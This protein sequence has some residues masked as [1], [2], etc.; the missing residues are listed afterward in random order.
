[1]FI[2][3]WTPAAF[4][5]LP[6]FADE[7][8]V[9]ESELLNELVPQL[10]TVAPRVTIGSRG[11][12]WADARGLSAELLP[13]DLLDVFHRND[14]EKVRA[15]ISLVPI[16]A[17]VAAL[18]GKGGLIR[19]PVGTEREFLAP[20]PIGVLE[21]SPFLASLLDGIGVERCADLAKLDLESIE[22]RFGAEGANLWRLARADDSRRIF[23][24]VPRSTGSTTLCAT[25]S[26]SSSSSTRSSE[27][28]PPSSSRAGNA[29]VR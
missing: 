4:P 2:C 20:F 8:L 1:M 23:K 29:R 10:L 26:D 18:H 17:E 13:K 15:A 6:L 12:V 7:G 22:V 11:V 9:Q 27:T 5:A 24:T 14:V 21:A 28:S 3:F 16:A 19:I 25:P